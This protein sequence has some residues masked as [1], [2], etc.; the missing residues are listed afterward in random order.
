MS[1][2]SSKISELSTRIADTASQDVTIESGSKSRMLLLLGGVVLAILAAFLI[3]PVISQWMLVEESVPR[4]RVRIAI[5]QRGDLIRD[6]SVQGRVVAAVSPTLYAN[7]EGTITFFVNP[8]DQVELGAKLAVVDSP[9]LA[10][11]LQQDE[12]LLAR[13]QVELER[14]DIQSKQQSLA[15]QKTVDL[16]QLQLTAAQRESR[17]AIDAFAKEAISQLD[18]EKAQDDLESAEYAHRH[19]VADAQLDNERLA[20]EKRTKQLEVDQQSIL[21]GDLR[22]QVE[23]LT[24]HSPVT[25]MVGNLLVAQKTNV[26]RN[27]PVLSVV[28]LSQFEV[29][30]QIPESYA[31]D[32]ALGMKAQILTTTSG[33]QVYPAILVSV[34]PE[35]IDNQVTARMR[36]AESVPTG[37]RQNQ[38]LTTRVLLE[39]KSNVLTVERGQFLD[40]GGGRIAYQVEGDVASRTS[41][42]VGARSLNRVEITQGLQAG[43][44]IVVSTTD[45]FNGADSVLLTD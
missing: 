42:E 17:R 4:E 2:P 8:G 38:R 3:W 6:V 35:I 33:G 21:V 18:Y 20:F 15:N 32:L 26:S 29:E 27:Q 13:K 23:D 5:V 44:Q 28:D 24:L 43:D 16:A 19:A 41:I 7:S 12:A 30:A 39:E 22:R 40:T 14:Q 9:E 1:E 34:S 25:G 10:N 37:L 45:I 31:D 11:R 36:F